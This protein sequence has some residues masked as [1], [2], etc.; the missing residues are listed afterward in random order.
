MCVFFREVLHKQQLPVTPRTQHG[1][2]KTR[3]SGMPAW[4]RGK[5]KAHRA[6]NGLAQNIEKLI[7]LHLRPQAQV[8]DGVV[9][10]AVRRLM[11]ETGNDIDDLIALFPTNMMLQFSIFFLKKTVF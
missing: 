10:S 4:R 6:C 3:K 11:F 1:T 8:D 7:R 9:D 5:Q 2:Q